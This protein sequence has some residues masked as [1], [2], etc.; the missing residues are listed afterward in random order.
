MDKKLEPRI[1]ANLIVRIWGMA[2]GKPFF[3]N[4]HAVDLSS[5]GAKLSDIEHAMAPGDVI[6]VQF[7]DKKARFRVVWLIDSGALH[8][9]QA[10]VQML[11]GQQCPWQE[12]LTNPDAEVASQVRTAAQD[13]RR[14]PRHKIKF[15][16]ELYDPRT[17]GARL[18]T[19]ATDISGRGC[20]VQTMMPL[21]LGTA[22]NI[23]FWMEDQRV[24][25]TGVVSASDGGVGMGIDFTGLDG[26]WQDRL[27]ARLRELDPASEESPKRGS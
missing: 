13:K 19:D 1:K 4:V 7:G 22:L 24:E 9:M 17:R 14:F 16:I 23:T 26:E 10:G 27:Q 6:G 3:Q 5:A 18:H 2:A 21:P 12:E 25:T 11:E 15:P 20:Y 8:K